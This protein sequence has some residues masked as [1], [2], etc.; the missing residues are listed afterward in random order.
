MLLDM[1][2]PL[3]QV[4]GETYGVALPYDNEAL[5]RTSHPDVWW[6]RT[7]SYTRRDFPTPASPTTATT[8]P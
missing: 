4:N 2:V 5:S 6:E 1:G 8:W 3:E 7:N